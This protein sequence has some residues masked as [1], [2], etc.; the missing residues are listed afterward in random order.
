MRRWLAYPALLACAGCIVAGAQSFSTTP[1]PPAGATVIVPSSA[2]WTDSDL[3][4]R[5]G[6]QLHLEAAASAG[7]CRPEGNPQWPADGLALASAAPGAL[8]ARIDR[9]APFAVGTRADLRVSQPGRLYLGMNAAN[10][11]LCDG[12]ITVTLKLADSVAPAES[13]ASAPATAQS[14]AAQAG[15]AA[16]HAADAKSKLAAAFQTWLGGQFGST[17]TASANN[18]N[19]ANA[20]HDA[21]TANAASAAPSPAAA[22][23]SSHLARL[24]G[25]G[26]TLDAKFAKDLDALPRRVIDEFKN[27][28]DM[29]NFVLVGS[30]QQLQAALAA[31]SW[32]TADTSKTGAAVNAILQT[33][34][35][36]DYLQMPMSI[37]YLFG[38]PQ[39][40]GYEQAEPYAVVAS[41][42]HFRLWKAA[43][44]WNNLPVWVGAGTHDIGFEKDQR[45]GKVTHKIDPLVDGERDHIGESLAQSGKASQA[46]YYLPPDPVQE[47]RNATGGSY[48][49]DG[50]ILVIFLQ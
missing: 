18:A 9:Q 19:S 32:H 15:A 3:D 14:A 24:T 49:S 34:Q 39:D 37:L 4:L 47:A 17:N 16:T 12:A 44:T 26:A 28:G 25:S 8:I 27:L 33:Y 23:T 36:Q 31:A 48:R 43:F 46:Y 50:R 11:A 5:A 1:P 29:V 38:R 30:Q 13:A 41:R 22:S 7:N 20:N 6:D 10:G 40:F 21:S 35:K 2:Q 42:H 45:N